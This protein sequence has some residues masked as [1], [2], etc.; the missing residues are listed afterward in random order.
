[1]RRP[2]RPYR[3]IAMS[4]D[5]RDYHPVVAPIR[6]PSSQRLSVKPGFIR[7][8]IEGGSYETAMVV[9]LVARK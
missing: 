3:R 7:P 5:D 8:R 9:S 4:E 2:A 1:V 6:G